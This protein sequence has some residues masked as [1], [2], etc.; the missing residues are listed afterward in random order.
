MHIR[1]MFLDYT[2]DEYDRIVDL[3]L[4][5]VFIFLRA[6]GRIMR[7]QNGGSLIATS[8]MRATTL[9]PGLAIYGATKAGIIQLVRGWLPNSAATAC[10]STP[11]SRASSRRRWWRR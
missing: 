7:D 11:S 9:E 6:F 8:S 2:D 5:G 4:R 3:N 1:K 10:A